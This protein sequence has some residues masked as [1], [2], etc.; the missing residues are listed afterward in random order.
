[1][2]GKT[3]KKRNANTNV[4]E[5]DIRVLTIN[6]N[7]FVVGLEW[8]TIKSHR[9]VMQEVKRIGKAR[10][11]DVVAIRKAEAIQAGFAPKSR[12]KLR[13]AYSLI[14]SLASL[15]EGS[16][17]A[18]ISLGINAD[19]EEEYTLVGRTA[20]GAIHPKS[21]TIHPESRIKQVVLDLK[22]D[23]RGNQQNTEIT[24]YGD[25]DRFEWVTESLDLNGV[26]KPKNIKKDYRLKPLHWGLTKGQLLISVIGVLLAV[27]GVYLALD[28]ADQQE[29][30]K[31]AAAQAMRLKQEEIN[32][33]AR[34]QAALDKL[35]H[36][37]IT[38]SSVPVLLKGCNDGLKKFE[39]SL[40]GWTLTSL[41]C[42]QEGIEANYSRPSNSAV[43]ADK[44]VSA[45]KERFD[46]DPIFNITQT[47]VS[48]FFVS[49]NLPP[50]GD[51]PFVNMGE[52]LIKVVSLFQSVNVPASFSEVS[53]KEEKKNSEGEDM[54][55]QD[56][57]EYTFS[58]QTN[59]P[60]ELIFKDKEY[61]GIRLNSIV[62]EFGQDDGSLT[63]KITGS[64]YGKR[65]IKE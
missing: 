10:N 11:L 16:C 47:S 32:K 26:L 17:I 21:D 45:V 25:L 64:L 28:Y 40:K 9:K 55:P 46:T 38:T 60:A 62:Y 4:V 35:K 34:Y 2:Y 8:E 30:I 36:P 42:T 37:W 58:V 5:K 52:Q 20:K 24:V 29:Q 1:M 56:W 51:D 3:K 6:N 44:F 57:Q 63:Y 41:R 33:Q 18:V 13:G 14:V 7:R 22:Q 43:T 65:I 39:L 19:G 61:T 27:T 23:L 54:P 48:V 31:R 15:L 49:H 50:N 12:Q 53:I 59:V